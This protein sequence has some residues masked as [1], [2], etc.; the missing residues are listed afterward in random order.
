M[1]S[2]SLLGWLSAE[3][4]TNADSK[5]ERDPSY[6]ALCTGLI[7]KEM[8]RNVGHGRSVIPRYIDGANVFTCPIFKSLCIVCRKDSSISAYRNLFLHQ[9]QAGHI[10]S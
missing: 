1:N 3:F 7:P 10:W 6:T 4:A 8:M 2:L 5:Q 9:K